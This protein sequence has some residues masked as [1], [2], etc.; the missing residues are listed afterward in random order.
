[1]TPSKDFSFFVA[2]RIFWLAE[3][4]D[5][6]VGTGL[7]DRSGKAGNFLGHHFEARGHWIATTNVV[8]ETGLAYLWK[9]S[10]I[11]NLNQPGTPNDKNSTYVYVST[12]LRF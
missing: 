12:T 9:G 2:H 4:K 7:Q 11:E 5:Q 6:W 1:L 3:A 8:F 10:F